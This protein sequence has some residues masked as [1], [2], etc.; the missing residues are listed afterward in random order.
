[1]RRLATSGSE[2]ELQIMVADYIRYRYPSVI[3][4]SDYGSGLKLTYNQ[5]WKQA[6]QNGVR[7]GFPDMTIFHPNW[8]AGKKSPV[9]FIELKKAGTRLKKR[10]G[11]WA[12]EHIAEQAKMMENLRQCG[13][14]AEFGVGFIQTRKIIDNYLEGV[15]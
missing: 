11:S 2:Q 3:F 4:R 7:K 12:S 5:S 9:L 1:M 6:R 15:R 13:H 10:D 14:I 8:T